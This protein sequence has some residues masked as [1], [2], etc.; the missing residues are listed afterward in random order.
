MIKINKYRNINN[1]DK[2]YKYKIIIYRIDIYKI[3]NN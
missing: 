3:D 1:I 2:I